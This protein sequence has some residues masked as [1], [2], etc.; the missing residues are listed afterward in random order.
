MPWLVSLRG[1]AAQPVSGGD[2]GAVSWLYYSRFPDLQ[3]I[4]V[5]ALLVKMGCAAAGLMLA[6]LFIYRGTGW[7]ERVQQTCWCMLA[8]L[9]AIALSAAA[10]LRWFA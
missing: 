4:A 9:A 3:G 7:N 2:F 8:T 1:W 10:F 6:A 5:T